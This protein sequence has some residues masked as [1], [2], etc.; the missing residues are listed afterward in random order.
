MNEAIT[1]I[2]SQSNVLSIGLIPDH[3]SQLR[4]VDNTGNPVYLHLP[5]DCTMGA[6]TLHHGCWDLV[7][8]HFAE[9]ALSELDSQIAIV[10]VGA[11]F[12]LFTRQLLA[13]DNRIQLAFCYE[14]HPHN[15]SMLSLNLCNVRDVRLINNA[16]GVCESET[17]LHRDCSNFGNCSSDQASLSGPFETVTVKQVSANTERNK[18]EAEFPDGE[19]VY[20]SDTQGSDIAIASGITLAFWLKV[21]C[22]FFELW[23][24]KLTEPE[25]IAFANILNLFSTKISDSDHSK[26]LTTDDVID[27]V[28]STPSGQSLDLMCKK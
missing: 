16:L 3:N 17:E 7:K 5:F 20:K 21:R 13:A 28:T 12:G 26:N 6:Q 9:Q 14:P 10:D 19:F 1:A 22:A 25:A 18:W 11:S 8:I 4:I 15:F 24:A 27:W 2:K 23:P